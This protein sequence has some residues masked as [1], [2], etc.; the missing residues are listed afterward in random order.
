VVKN[1]K[2]E[3]VMKL[4]REKMASWRRL[5]F[6]LLLNPLNCRLFDRWRPPKHFGELGER[7]AER[8]LLRL[9]YYIVARNYAGPHGEIDIVAVDGRTVVFV[10]VKARMTSIAGHAAEAVDDE[11]ELKL[12]KTAAEY[13]MFHGLE[14]AHKRFDVVAIDMDSPKNPLRH[15]INAF[16]SAV[17]Y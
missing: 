10:E 12:S 1:Y 17:D 8:Y 2:P 9:G 5:C 7:M 16:E 14:N 15:F 4:N 3:T 13:V 6:S 11:K